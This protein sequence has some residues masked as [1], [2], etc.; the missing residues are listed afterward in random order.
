MEITTADANTGITFRAAVN[1]ALQALV[2]NNAGATAPTTPY[3]YMFWPDTTT[4]L[5]K[6]RNAAND[7]WITI[8]TLASTGLGLVPRSLFDANTI[9]AANVDDTPA[10]VT[11]AEQRLV[12]R[13]T[14]GNIAGLDSAEVMTILDFASPGAIGETT[15]NTIRALSKEII[16]ASSGS[17]SAAEVAGTL[18]NNYGQAAAVTLTLPTCAAGM[19]FV[20][21][22]GTTY[23]NYYRID[24][25]ATDSVFL[26][27]VTTGDGKYIGIASAVKGACITFMAFQTGSG[28]YDWLATGV[29]GTWAAEA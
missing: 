12:G 5:L 20:V 8:G 27:G 3:A 21:I 14:G 25:A 9:I 11:V 24:P 2:S 17:L 10:A 1:A 4:G 19:S 16:K 29:N 28:A 18:I 22:L 26:S 23:A 7:A 15:P 13:K 6:I